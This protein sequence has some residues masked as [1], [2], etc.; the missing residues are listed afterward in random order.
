MGDRL[1][2]VL[3]TILVVL[4]A[5][6]ALSFGKWDQGAYFMANAAVLIGVIKL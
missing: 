5:I 4:A 2:M 3:S 6:S 1:L